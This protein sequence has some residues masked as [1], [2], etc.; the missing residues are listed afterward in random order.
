MGRPLSKQQLFGANAGNNIKVQ[1]YNGS[2]SVPGYIVEQTGS[3]R[4]ICSDA[5]GN[6][7]TCYLVDKASA[8]LGAGEMTITL[9]YDDN[10]VQQATK[11]TRHKVT[12]D[13]NGSVQSMPWNFSTSTSDGAWQ[14][15]E[16]G[17]DVYMTS[18]TDLEGDEAYNPSLDYPVPG[19]GSYQAAA[20]ALSGLTYAA[21]GTPY[22][23]GGAL[24]SVPESHPGLRR[25]KYDGNFCAA[26]DTL[27]ASWVYNFFGTATVLKSLAD[28]YVSWGQQSD[29]A[30]TGEH[31]FS[32]EWLG[33]VQAPKSG[34]FNIYAESDDHCAVWIGTAATGTPRNATRS[35]AAANQS[36]PGS[37]IVAGT[38]VNTNSVTLV[39]DNGIRFVFGT[40]N[41]LAD[42]K[43]SYICN[44]PTAQTTTV[45]T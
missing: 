21:Q 6:Q 2:S 43:H 38:T 7:A 4:F 42:V 20:D 5:D 8:A 33:Y 41:S 12:V 26:N 44:I 3:K 9:K 17:S 10:T 15:E 14:I 1:F 30:G 25:T 34:N 27:P 32:C 18:A 11:I 22:A 16:A 31:N 39:E 29:G 37:G 24:T 45:V 40:V 13:Y 19:S 28:T 36:L 23:P 35:L